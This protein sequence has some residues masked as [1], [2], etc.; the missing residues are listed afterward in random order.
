MAHRLGIIPTDMT[1]V[2]VKLIDGGHLVSDKIIQNMNW[3][4]QGHTYC[5]S[6]RVLDIGA[7]DA[8]LG[9]AWLKTHSPMLYD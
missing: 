7:Y 2:Q 8:I 4:A 9:Y 3:W 6:M 1:P 5:N